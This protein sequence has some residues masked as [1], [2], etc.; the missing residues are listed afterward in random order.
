MLMPEASPYFDNRLAWRKDEVRTAW[1]AW[2]VQSVAVTHAMEQTMNGHLCLDIFSFH[3]AHIGATG[4]RNDCAI[5]LSP[6]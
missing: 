1:Q 2:F 4:V 3:N 5:F 6:H